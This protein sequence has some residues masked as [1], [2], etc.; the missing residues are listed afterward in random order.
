MAVAGTKVLLGVVFLGFSCAA[1]LTMLHLLGTP[2]TPHARVLRIVHRLTGGIAVA[3]YVVIS[4][5]C[6]AGAG[7][8]GSGISPSIAIHVTFAALFIPFILAKVVIVE[9]YP[10]LRNRLFAIGTV[11]FALV[12][13]IFFASAMSSLV[14][15]ARRAETVPSPELGE[16]VSLGRELFV[17]KCAKCHRLDIPL[18][19]RKSP[20]E[21]RET[22]STMRQKDRA[23]ISALE[24]ERITEFLV[25][26]GGQ[27]GYD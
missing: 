7:Q 19:A 20:P 21:W 1:F 15:T 6:I 3:L 22:V 23:W 18:S 5:I 2:H 4:V 25:S 27:P 12:F 17:I 11:L 9:K 16:A 10:E 24:A 14:G 26:L 13:V 8:A